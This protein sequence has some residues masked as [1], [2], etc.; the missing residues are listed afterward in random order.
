MRAV[1]EMSRHLPSDATKIDDVQHE[2]QV[3][4]PTNIE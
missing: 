1:K 4:C 2:I 3:K